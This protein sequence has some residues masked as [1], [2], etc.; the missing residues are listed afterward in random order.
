M[1]RNQYSTHHAC[2]CVLE[3]LRAADEL[4]K[5]VRSVMNGLENHFADEQSAP[6]RFHHELSEALASYEKL[7]GSVASQEKSE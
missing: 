3:Q 5:A 4:A 7:R 2:D 6:A 1:T